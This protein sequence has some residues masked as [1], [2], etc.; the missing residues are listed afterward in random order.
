MAELN[1]PEYYDKAKNIIEPAVCD[2]INKYLNAE[3]VVAYLPPVIML[4]FS[5][6]RLHDSIDYAGHTDI[7]VHSFKETNRF[8]TGH[9]SVD[10]KTITKSN[11]RDINTN[12]S[13]S[14]Q[15]I[16]GCN[17][18]DYF[19]FVYHDTVHIVKSSI[20]KSLVTKRTSSKTGQQFYT[21]P[22]VEAMSNSVFTTTLIW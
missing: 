3:Q 20:V 15:E 12:F 22:L 13:V 17:T 18:P 7:M 14:I 11:D 19:A 4:P 10:V 2:A 16:D 1:N 9:F 8:G 21:F 6:G 5:D